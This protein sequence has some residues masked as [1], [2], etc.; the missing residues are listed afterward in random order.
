MFIYTVLVCKGRWA[1]VKAS[2]SHLISA[3]YSGDSDGWLNMRL[4]IKIL[5]NLLISRS[6]MLTGRTPMCVKLH[7]HSS[8]LWHWCYELIDVVFI[9]LH[10]HHN[11]LQLSQRPKQRQQ[12]KHDHN[13]PSLC[14][15]E[16]ILT[17]SQSDMTHTTC[18]LTHLWTGMAHI[19]SRVHPSA[20]RHVKLQSRQASQAWGQ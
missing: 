6:K 18:L 13:P 9:H 14:Q 11:A 5:C 20:T 7:H 15:F 16:P 19:T 8:F 17:D 3:V 1:G 2:E 4:W 10:W 12:D